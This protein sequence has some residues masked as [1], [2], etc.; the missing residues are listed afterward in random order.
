MKQT[1]ISQ[2]THADGTVSKY[3]QWEVNTAFTFEI[4]YIIFERQNQET[5]ESVKV[6]RFNAYGWDERINAKKVWDSIAG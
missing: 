3:V 6:H 5:K 2:V 1:L 4:G